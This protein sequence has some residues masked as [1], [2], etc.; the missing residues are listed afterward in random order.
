MQIVVY[1]KIKDASTGVPPKQKVFQV[2]GQ[3]EV[4]WN[5]VRIQQRY[6]T[7]LLPFRKSLIIC[8]CSVTGDVTNFFTLEI[9]VFMTNAD[10]IAA[11]FGFYEGVMD[12]LPSA[13]I[14]LESSRSFWIS[15]LS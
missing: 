4:K 7:S 10:T 6:H 13:H 5:S 11:W 3:R 8:V 12:T 9:H 14:S 2:V 1:P 15:T